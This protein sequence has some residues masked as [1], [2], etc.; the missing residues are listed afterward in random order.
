MIIKLCTRLLGAATVSAALATYAAAATFLDTYDTAPVLSPT[1]APGAYYTDRYAP[2]GF[3][4]AFFMGDNRLK[5]RLSVADGAVNR[6]GGFSSSF[7]NTQGR[8]YD[9]P[10][11]VYASIEMFISNDFLSVPARIGGL[12]G[13]AVN[14][15]N[16]IVH[17]PIIEFANGGFQVWNGT[18][19]EVV[20]LPTWVAA[21]TFVEMAIALDSMTDTFTFLLNGHV[22]K[23]TTASGAVSL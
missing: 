12:W 11:A 7:Y 15:L 18:A 8:K 2:A 14:G 4:N 5:L 13:T 1:Q 17:Y 3:A 10:G 19:F 22:V 21:N 16:A 23:T 6:T 9:T 20:G